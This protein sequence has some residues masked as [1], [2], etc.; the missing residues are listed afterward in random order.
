MIFWNCG[1]WKKR[2]RLAASIILDSQNALVPVITSSFGALQGS[3]MVELV[4]A[5]A[6]AC[7]F[8]ELPAISPVKTASGFVEPL[9]VTLLGS[10]GGD[11]VLLPGIMLLEPPLK[12]GPV[13]LDPSELGSVE[14]LEVDS[15]RLR[16]SVGELSELAVELPSVS[17]VGVE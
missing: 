13:G 2:I 3:A 8:V 11:V 10:V 14:L 1:F 17:V 5:V 7:L 15:P 6:G 12:V 4:S 9:V 16:L